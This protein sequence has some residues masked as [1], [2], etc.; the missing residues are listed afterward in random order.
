MNRAVATTID[1]TNII[2]FQNYT[3]DYMPS[4]LY[5]YTIGR[6]TLGLAQKQT[7]QFRGGFLISDEAWN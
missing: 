4:S 3:L 7:L 2:Q 5:C 6:R 1:I